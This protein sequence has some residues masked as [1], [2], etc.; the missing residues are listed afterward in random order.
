MAPIAG[1]ALPAPNA[2][3]QAGGAKVAVLLP[4]SGPNAELGKAMLDAAQLALFTMGSDGL[5]LVPRDTGGTAGG[6]AKAAQSAIADGAQLILGPLLAAEVAAVKPIAMNA[7]VNVIGYSTA[8]QLAGSNVF[9]MGFLPH[10]EVL[11]EVAYARE[12][13]LGRFAALLPNSPY[14]HLIEAALR[15]GVA[16]SGGQP[17]PIV[18]FGPGGADAASA[19][20]RLLGKPAGAGA[21]PAAA[22]APAPAAFD[23]LLLPEG[24]TQLK[25]LAGQIKAA[26]IDTTQVRLLG[27]G[28]WDDPSVTG[29][30][31]LYGG[32]Y[33]TSPPDARHDFEN[34]Y[35][36]A[37][38]QTPPRLAS[39]A[40]DSA[41]LAAVLAKAGGD[42]PFSREAILNP[43]GFTG[44]DG[45]FRFTSAGLVQRGLAVLEI[46][47]Q[48][49]VVVGPAPQSFAGAGL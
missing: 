10:D 1:V 5:T 45:L 25:Q 35:Q 21:A 16:A 48:G 24:G 3:T 44:V 4:L 47:P 38:H 26:G 17:G 34:R 42:H 46:E 18:Y 27:S 20:Q 32:W 36:A 37:Y 6:A 33:A 49:P 19:V 40:F 30:P 22:A 43:N 39:L 12:K 13:G 29:D 23:A 9:L 28:L 7:N 11:R 41:A 2:P 15:D 8:T 14:G 31:A